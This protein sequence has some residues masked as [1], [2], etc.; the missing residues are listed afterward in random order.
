MQSEMCWQ[1]LVMTKQKE[2]FIK[3]F[4]RVKFNFSLEGVGW[5]HLKT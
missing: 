5:G 2:L 1:E 4:K 3:S